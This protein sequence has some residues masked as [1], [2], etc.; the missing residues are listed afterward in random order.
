MATI[1]DNSFASG[2]TDIGGAVS[3]L[4]G[5]RGAAASAGSYRQ[6]AGIANQNAILAAQA[7]AIKQVQESRKLYQTIGK[8]EAQVGGAGFAESGTALNLL[9]SSTSQ[10]ALTKAM[11]AESGA[12]TQNSYAQQAAQFNSMADAAKSSSTAQTIG[13]VL[14]AAGGAYQLYNAGKGL[15]D[16]TTVDTFEKGAAASGAEVATGA[17]L[18]SGAVGSFGAAAGAAEIGTIAAES[19]VFA[20]LGWAAFAL[21]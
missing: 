21:A 4:F 10:G 20:D 18:A 13:G 5:A 16:L 12:I 15:F 2:L 11:I 14:Q 19:S 1:N 8:Q 3:A 7:T 6:A 17:E 9:R